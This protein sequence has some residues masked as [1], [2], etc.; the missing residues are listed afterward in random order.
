MSTLL[1]TSSVLYASDPAVRKPWRNSFRCRVSGISY[2]SSLVSECFRYKQLISEL[3][4]SMSHEAK[5]LTVATVAETRKD[6]YRSLVTT[7]TKDQCV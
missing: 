7:G 4:S 5:G 2:A 1:F 6:R 3:I